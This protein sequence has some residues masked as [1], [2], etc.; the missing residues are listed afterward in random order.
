TGKV[1]LGHPVV[2]AESEVVATET[3]GNSNT[4]PESKVTMPRKEA[5]P[6]APIVEK[7]ESKVNVSI[8]PSGLST[9]IEIEYINPEG[10][11]DT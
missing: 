5:T 11:S 3:K 1:T 8:I 4:S 9:K 10:Q 7:D 2:Q 6:D